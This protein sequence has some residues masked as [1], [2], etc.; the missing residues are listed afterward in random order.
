MRCPNVAARRLIRCRVAR[1]WLRGLQCTHVRIRWHPMNGLEQELW[2]THLSHDV[3]ATTPARPAPTPSSSMR[4][5]AK[6]R[7]HGDFAPAAGWVEGHLGDAR[8]HG[9]T[10]IE[11]VVKPAGEVALRIR[12]VP[13][14][15]APVASPKR[16]W[17]LKELTLA[18]TKRQ[19]SASPCYHQSA[20]RATV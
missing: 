18:K 5:D 3:C 14:P 4:S 9:T 1:P 15:Q 16:P 10:C 8:F 20:Y 19:I 6:C 13:L 2:L 11:W 17:I 7:P 12:C